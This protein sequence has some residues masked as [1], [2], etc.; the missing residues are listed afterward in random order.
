MYP[1]LFVI[2]NDNTGYEVMSKEQLEYYFRI[3]K[4]RP[5]SMKQRRNVMVGGTLAKSHYFITKVKNM[6][7]TEIEY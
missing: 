1:R 6:E 7:D 4:N 5:E 3:A 2:N